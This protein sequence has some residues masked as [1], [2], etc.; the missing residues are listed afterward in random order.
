MA[1]WIDLRLRPPLT[2]SSELLR[3]CREFGNNVKTNKDT[4]RPCMTT[5]G[6]M[7]VTATAKTEALNARKPL[8]FGNWVQSIEGVSDCLEDLV[9]A[10]SVAEQQQACIVRS[11]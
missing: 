6:Y 7:H 2:P 11:V 5:I 1:R 8:K 9:L 3:L 10:T 4:L